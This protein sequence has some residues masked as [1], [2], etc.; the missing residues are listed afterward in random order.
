MFVARVLSQGP[1]THAGLINC[2]SLV[3]SDYEF[4]VACLVCKLC[5]ACVLCDACKN[6]SALSFPTRS[7]VAVVVVVFMVLVV[8]GEREV[9]VS[10]MMVLVVVVLALA[11]LGGFRV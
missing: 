1:P 8:L 5:L 11:Y 3:C 9:M 7:F 4:R 2:A 6:N 10:V